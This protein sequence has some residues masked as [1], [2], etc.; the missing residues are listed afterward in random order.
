M[1]SLGGLAVSL[2]RQLPFRAP[3]RLAPQRIC[4]FA[5]IMEL[6]TDATERVRMS[7]R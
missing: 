7:L 2:P 1:Q 4:R 5:P 3:T 6:S